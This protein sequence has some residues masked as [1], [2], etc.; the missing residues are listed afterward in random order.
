MKSGVRGLTKPKKQ[1]EFE[2][3][4]PKKKESQNLKESAKASGKMGET[5]Y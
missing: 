5:N 4:R 1:R 3:T 2:T